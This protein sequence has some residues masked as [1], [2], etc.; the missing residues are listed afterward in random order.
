VD[1]AANSRWPRFPF[2][3][4]LGRGLLLV[5]DGK[6]GKDRVVMLARSLRTRLAEQAERRRRQHEHDRPHGGAWV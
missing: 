1:C 2:D 6:G 3:V 4:D 5:R